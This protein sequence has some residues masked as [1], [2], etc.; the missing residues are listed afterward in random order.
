MKERIKNIF[1]KVFKLLEKKQ[2]ISFI[3]IFFLLVAS[4]IL[5]QVTPLAVG[6]LTDSVLTRTGME[7]IGIM[8]ILLLI[9]AANVSGET[10]KIVRR[11]FIESTSTSTEKNARQRAAEA[12]LKAPLRYFRRNLTGN[13][14]GR[15]NRSIEGTVRLIKLVFMEFAP[16]LFSGIAAIVII[17]IKLPFAIA[18]TSVMVI[19]FGVFIVLRQIASQQG[20][21]VELMNARA[22]M[23]GTIVELLGGIETIR[24]LDSTG[25]EELR[26]LEKSELLR[27]NEMKHHMAMA[28]YDCCKFLN[29]ALFHVLVIGFSTYYALSGKITVGTVLSAYLCFFQMTGPLRELHRILDEFSEALV[30]AEDYFGILNIAPDASYR[31]TEENRPH[32]GSHEI[33]ISGV[34][35]CYTEKPDAKILSDFSL[36]IGEGEFL[37]IAGPSGCG[38]S[39][40][41]RLIDRLE[42]GQGQI[43][44]GGEDMQSFSRAALAS[45][46]VLVPQTPF[47]ISDTIANNITYGM[48]EKISAEGIHYAAKCANMDKVIENLPGGYDFVLS[49]GGSNLSGGQRQ[50]IAL[51]RIFARTPDVLILDEATS[52]LDNTSEKKIIEEIVRLKEEKNITVIS[53][54]HRLSTLKKC[55]RIIVMDQGRIVQSGNYREL[56]EVPGVFQTMLR[57]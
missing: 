30:L 52:A 21:R 23:D 39:T 31:T 1:L 12:L 20:I 48:K 55:D 19:P 29:E 32:T 28:G 41:I 35:F 11:L 18:L 46:I 2:K 43:L 57:Q 15:L 26:I 4:A 56:S 37:G 13:I 8:P 45:R 22:E 16:S 42:H 49:E 7:F 27:K 44:M 25:M 36:T 54:A 5:T 47:L 38:K 14:H 24:S 40:L 51:A 33:V 34:N 10:L 3:V 17:F 9:L 6:Y 53:I 50:R